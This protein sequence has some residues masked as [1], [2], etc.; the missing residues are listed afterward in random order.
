MKNLVLT[1]GTL[2]LLLFA[3]QWGWP[4]NIVPG[5]GIPPG[6]GTG[7]VSVSGTPAAGN[8]AEWVNATTIGDAGDPCGTGGGGGGIS[9]ADQ[10]TAT[11]SDAHTADNTW[12]DVANMSLTLTV[13]ASGLLQ[14]W[15]QATYASISAN[16]DYNNFRFD[17]DS[18]TQTQ[19]LWRNALDT[20]PTNNP[21]RTGVVSYLFTGLSAGNHT[22]KLQTHDNGSGQNRTIT[23]R[24]MHCI[25]Y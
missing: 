1:A 6:G 25:A 22:V 13:A 5:T 7:D 14:C 15:A 24:S 17:L 10:V 2:L 19:V 11:S 18:T 20:N 3:A 21:V 8:C 4:Q 12:E 9:D 23:N 16:W